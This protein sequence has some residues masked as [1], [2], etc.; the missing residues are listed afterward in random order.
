MI[1]FVLICSAI[2]LALVA[3]LSRR[4]DLRELLVDFSIDS[5]LIEPDEQI[6]LRYSVRNNSRWPVLYAALTLQIEPGIR[7]CEDEAWLQRNTRRDSMGTQIRRHFFLM[8]RKKTSGRLRV[9]CTRRGQYRIGRYYLMRG[10]FMG[11]DPVLRSGDLGLRLICTARRCEIPAPETLGGVMGEVPVRRF[12]LDDPCMLRGYREYTGREPMKQISWKQTA[13]VGRLMVRQNDYTTDRVA[14][15][16][17]N[18]D[19]SQRPQLE[20]CLKLVR[21]VCE[22]LEEKK[23]PY[24]LMSNG[25][26]LSIPEGIG[27]GHLFFILRRLGM[28]R[29]AGFTTFESLV[30]RCVRRRRSNCS[31]IVITPLLG[32]EGK[33]LI[34]RLSRHID[35]RPIVMVPGAK[36]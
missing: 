22:E 18:M 6:S 26:L 4:D 7:V 11:L 21:T 12:I 2:L 34:G 30:E 10:D 27:R 16:M 13:K 1:V 29:L 17:V 33:S 8:P 5:T 32:P 25:D 36:G 3:Q 31:Y 23:V 24:E 20:E 9:C 35:S 15:V 28:S 19:S 14:V